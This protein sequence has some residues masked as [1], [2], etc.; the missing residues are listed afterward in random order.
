M[1]LNIIENPIGMKTLAL[2]TEFCFV[3]PLAQ[4]Q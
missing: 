2:A 3:I 1:E 4:I